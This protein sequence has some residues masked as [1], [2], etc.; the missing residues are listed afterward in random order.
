MK[1]IV[2]PLWI[3]I[4]ANLLGVLPAAWYTP[5]N[6]VGALLVV[7]HL[8]EYFIFQDKIKARG[9]SP[10]NAFIQTMLFGIL[11]FGKSSKS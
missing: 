2:L 7:A 4:V 8:A 6:V 5:L 9:D 10:L 11:Y 3:A 1:F